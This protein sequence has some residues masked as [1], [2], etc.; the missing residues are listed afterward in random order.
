METN[1]DRRN[2]NTKQKPTNENDSR[3]KSTIK[4]ENCFLITQ[5]VP[6]R[7]AA[8]CQNHSAVCSLH[9]INVSVEHNFAYMKREIYGGH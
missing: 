4:T 3:K 1:S 5:A 9:L 2:S 7:F 6:F 8:N